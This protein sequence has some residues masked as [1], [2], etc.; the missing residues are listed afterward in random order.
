MCASTDLIFNSSGNRKKTCQWLHIA[1]FP[2]NKVNIEKERKERIWKRDN[3]IRVSYVKA[4]TSSSADR[5]LLYKWTE[6]LYADGH[7]DGVETSDSAPA[8]VVLKQLQQVSDDK[9]PQGLTWG[10]FW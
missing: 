6:V 7:M 8:V 2:K 9:E 10:T 5:G 1:P 3:N 4:Y